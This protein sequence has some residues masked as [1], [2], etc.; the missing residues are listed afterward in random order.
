MLR[1]LGLGDLLTAIPA[2]R[3]VRR[4]LPA[5]ELVLGMPA[6]LE[7]LICLAGELVDH[8]LPTTGLTKIEWSGA[9]PDVAVNLHG[10]GPQSHE[11]LL[12][13]DPGWLVAFSQHLLDV[14]GPDWHAE[15]HEVVRWCRLVSESFDVAADP[16]E[17]SLRTPAQEPP[18]RGAVVIHPGAAY[19]S[20]RWPAERFAAVAK[21]AARASLPVAITGGQTEHSLAVEVANAGGLAETT[22][23]AGRTTLVE[24]AALVA[25][26]RLLVSGDTG[27]AHLASAFCTPSVV[28]FGPVP[29]SR[30]GPPKRQQHVALW[31]KESGAGDPWGLSVDPALLQ[32]SVEEVISAAEA[33]LAAT[34]TSRPSS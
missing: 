34:R 21:W 19:A 12:N 7:P 24:L 5:H 8:V 4:A 9:P 1:A 2:L 31:P 16:T 3:A 13:L 32:I 25:D 11:T 28:L 33:Q 29:P 17:L 20:R 18:V 10:R 26:A 22:V 6:V 30:W 15:E 27:I 23:L 14:A